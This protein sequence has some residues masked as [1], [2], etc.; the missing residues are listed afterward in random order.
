MPAVNYDLMY[1]AAVN[2][3]N[4]NANQIVFWSHFPLIGKT[5]PSLRIQTRFT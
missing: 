2:L 3:L 1:Q 5:R 4:G